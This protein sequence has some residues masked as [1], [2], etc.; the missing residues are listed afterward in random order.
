MTT[1]VVEGYQI[2]NRKQVVF[3]PETMPHSFQIK[4]SLS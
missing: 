3:F 2:H 1:T 4:C